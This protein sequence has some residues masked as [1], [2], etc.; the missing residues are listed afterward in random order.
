ME[1]EE[2]VVGYEKEDECQILGTVNDDGYVDVIEKES[3]LWDEVSETRVDLQSKCQLT[4]SAA[5]VA[6]LTAGAGFFLTL[7]SKRSR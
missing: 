4:L 6:A 3:P 5:L 1:N 7:Q 2:K